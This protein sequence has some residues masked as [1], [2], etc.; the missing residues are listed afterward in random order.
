[1]TRHHVHQSQLQA[2]RRARLLQTLQTQQA[3]HNT[4]RPHTT[5]R[6]NAD[7]IRQILDQQD[8]DDAYGRHLSLNDTTPRD[9]AALAAAS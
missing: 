1:L 7:L 3:E 4:F 8:E 5:A 6:Q 9:V 2:Q